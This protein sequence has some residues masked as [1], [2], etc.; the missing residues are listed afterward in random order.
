MKLHTSPQVFFV[1]S[2]KDVLETLFTGPTTASG[3]FKL[4]KNGV[5]ISDLKGVERVFV[6][7]IGDE[8]S[9]PHGAVPGRRPSVCPRDDARDSHLLQPRWNA[10]QDKSQPDRSGRARKREEGKLEPRILRIGVDWMKN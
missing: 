4:R 8:S 6:C 10:G 3:T 1:P 2:D 7:C 9:V 5:L